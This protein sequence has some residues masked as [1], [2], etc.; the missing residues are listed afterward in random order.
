MDKEII[1]LLVVGVL[2]ILV[3][4]F[5]LLAAY[6]RDLHFIYVHTKTGNRYRII[7]ECK[8]K[9]DGKCMDAIAYI[10]EKDN[11]IYVRKYDDFVLNFKRLSEWK[12][13]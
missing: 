9:Y 6:K 11:E 3:A 1:V 7:Q 5:T 12:K 13:D 4:A 2:A 8:M 10:S